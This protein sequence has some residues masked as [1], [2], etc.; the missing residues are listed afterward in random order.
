[1]DDHEDW[2]GEVFNQETITALQLLAPAT[3]EGM[4]YPPPSPFNQL[5][6]T[7]H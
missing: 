3:F 6:L 5:L 1:M 2:G 7:V 4:L